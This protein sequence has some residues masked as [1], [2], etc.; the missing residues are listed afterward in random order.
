M[1]SGRITLQAGGSGKPGAEDRFGSAVGRDGQARPPPERAAAPGRRR[2]A[3]GGSRRTQ[4]GW[5]RSGFFTGGE[6]A[7]TISV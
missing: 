3:F 6:F 4:P 5:I 1:R 7:A 2:Q